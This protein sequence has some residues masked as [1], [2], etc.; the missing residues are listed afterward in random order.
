[1]VKNLSLWAVYFLFAGSALALGWH[2]DLLAFNGGAGLAKAV[3]WA[4]YLA[5]LIFSIYCSLH[6]NI[7]RT[8]DQMLKLHWGRQIGLDLYIGI[9]MFMGLIY[10]H[11]GS[12]LVVALWL[13]PTVLF[14][15]LAT[16]LY[17]VINFESLLARFMG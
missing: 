12:L 2:D 10:L 7:F 15:N 5:F 9:T 16:F 4:A 11:E 17:L 6:E 3:V 13:V 14:A 1:M 8:I